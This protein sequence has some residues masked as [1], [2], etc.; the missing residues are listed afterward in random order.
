MKFLSRLFSVTTISFAEG[1]CTALR[2]KVERYR[3]EALRSCLVEA[4]VPRGEI[5]IG[6]DGR[7]TFSR[8]I[9]PALHQRLRNVL[10]T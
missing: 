2:G 5:W 4:D 8:E 6:S 9:G 7:I 3:L 10:H 1:R